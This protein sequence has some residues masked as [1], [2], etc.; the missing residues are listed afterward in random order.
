MPAGEN[1]IKSVPEMVLVIIAF[2]IL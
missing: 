1:K 2:T